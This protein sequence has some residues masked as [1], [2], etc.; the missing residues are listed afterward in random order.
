M[1]KLW[2]IIYFHHYLSGRQSCSSVLDRIQ[3]KQQTLLE[4]YATGYVVNSRIKDMLFIFEKAAQ[5]SPCHLLC[6]GQSGCGKTSLLAHFASSRLSKGKPCVYFFGGH[7]DDSLM[8]YLSAELLR[9]CLK[10]IQDEQ[11]RAPLDFFEY[12]LR[13]AAAHLKKD[14]NLFLVLDNVSSE[15]L[16]MIFAKV[17][18]LSLD[19]RVRCI[20]SCAIGQVQLFRPYHP[21]TN[22]W[23]IPNQADDKDALRVSSASS[24]LQFHLDSVIFSHSE[25]LALTE[26]ISDRL[27][28]RLTK[29]RKMQIAEQDVFPVPLFIFT[30]AAREASCRVSRSLIKPNFKPKS[31]QDLFVETVL[32]R[33]EFGWERDVIDDILCFMALSRGGIPL[34]L[35]I[36]MVYG[37]DN[38]PPTRHNL[39]EILVPLR[40]F[41]KPWL[42]D[43]CDQFEFLHES[44]RDCVLRNYCVDL[45]KPTDGY[46]AH[47]VTLLQKKL[48]MFLLI[49]ADPF[50]DKTWRGSCCTPFKELIYHLCEV[51]KGDAKDSESLDTIVET[52]C[53]LHYIHSVLTKHPL[54]IQGLLE[55]FRMATQVLKI[56]RD[57]EDVAKSLQADAIDAQLQQV[58][59]FEGFVL[60]N[61]KILSSKANSHLNIG[62]HESNEIVK[63]VVV[64]EKENFISILQENFKVLKG[65]REMVHSKCE[66][67]E[68]LC[69]TFAQLGEMDSKLQGFLDL[70]GLLLLDS[71]ETAQFIQYRENFVEDSMILRQIFLEE[72]K[73]DSELLD[74]G[75]VA[76]PK[77]SDGYIWAKEN[78]SRIESLSL[79]MRVCH[80]VPWADLG[81]SWETLFTRKS[82]FLQFSEFLDAKALSKIRQTLFKTTEVIERLF[83]QYSLLF[84]DEQNLDQDAENFDSRHLNQNSFN[85]SDQIALKGIWVFME[86]F[87]LLNEDCSLSLVNRWSINIQKSNSQTKVLIGSDWHLGEK[88]FHFQDFVEILLRIAQARLHRMP[89]LEAL[90]VFCKH[91]SSSIPGLDKSGKKTKISLTRE[92]LC[93]ED[94][95]SVL[96]SDV[97]GMLIT[98]EKRLLSCYE[99]FTEHSPE[100]GADYQAQQKTLNHAE[101]YLTLKLDNFHF[102][103][104]SVG[105]VDSVYSK[106]YPFHC[107]SDA[108]NEASLVTDPKF[109]N[110]AKTQE[111]TFVEFVGFIVS[112]SCSTQPHESTA[113]SL[114]LWLGRLDLIGGSQPAAFDPRAPAG[115]LWPVVGFKVRP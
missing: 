37:G 112:C 111:I 47:K 109:C 79:Q 22:E 61:E 57:M 72:L 114:R 6:H 113:E 31:V 11:S 41:L 14:E 24:L 8:Q 3:A 108:P 10:P 89:F 115:S 9:F 29:K 105:L 78:I 48:S 60:M 88:V 62:I 54:K 67:I 49:L 58:E 66:D 17:A 53:N 76:I 56:L 97:E 35:M 30:A 28:A 25:K 55:Q 26:R 2:D 84:A 70:G 36:Q 59:A 80:A 95:V 69:S 32:E 51:V 73:R 63:S 77:A 1:L 46:L 102:L 21:S 83:R 98:H 100:E 92:V 33:S 5:Q 40:L 65:T 27:D 20:V 44:Y 103:C 106:C 68:L 50:S 85:V 38:R 81:R 110:S 91:V 96:K 13:A 99:H 34:A 87:D 12:G 16:T 4:L 86:D 90:D 43:C 82:F 45:N 94:I 101:T 74:Y 104:K 71:E 15:P 64:Q 23:F 107:V 42:Q 93:N 7:G 52:I 19:L 75:P 18:V 39:M